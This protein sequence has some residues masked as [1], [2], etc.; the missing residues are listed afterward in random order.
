[1]FDVIVSIST[2]PLCQQRR[3]VHLNKRTIYALPSC[4]IEENKTRQI[5]LVDRKL[6]MCDI[7][8]I[9]ILNVSIF[10]IH[11]MVTGK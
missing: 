1:M 11:R 2:P 5:P 3:F 9:G 8:H 7:A 6:A 10:I 4:L